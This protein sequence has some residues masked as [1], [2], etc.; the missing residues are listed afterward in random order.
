MSI[1]SVNLPY[2]CPGR[3]LSSQQI[4]II[5]EQGT[6]SNGM[7]WNGMKNKHEIIDEIQKKKRKKWIDMRTK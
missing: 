7:V 1:S 6:E 5:Y 4:I 3:A 2:V